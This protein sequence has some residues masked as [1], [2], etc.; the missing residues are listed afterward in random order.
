MKSQ[1]SWRNIVVKFS[2]VID[3]ESK[4]E[5]IRKRAKFL[6][7]QEFRY[8]AHLGVFAIILPAPQKEHS[9]YV[10]IINKVKTVIF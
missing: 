10:A 2:Q 1:G 4:N 3:T 5:A 6:L 8:A 9:N 7:K